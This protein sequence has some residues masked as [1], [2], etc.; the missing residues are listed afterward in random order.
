MFADVEDGGDVLRI[1]AAWDGEAAIG[2]LAGGTPGGAEIGGEDG[3]IALQFGGGLIGAVDE[4]DA[5]TGGGDEDGEF[6]FFCSH[7]GRK[8]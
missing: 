8:N 4:F 5:T 1:V 7:F 6:G 3:E 2:A